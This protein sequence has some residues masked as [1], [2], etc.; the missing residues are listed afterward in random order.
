V[1]EGLEIAEIAA[2][3]AKLARGDKPLQT[4][5]DKKEIES[6]DLVKLYIDVGHKN[7]VRPQDIVGAIANEADIPGHAIGHIDIYD[8]FTFVE[9]P[10]RFKDQVLERMKLTKIRNRPVK[11]RAARFD[12]EFE[13]VAAQA[14]SSFAGAPRESR[15]SRDFRETKRPRESRDFREHREV[16]ETREA[17]P[18]NKRKEVVETQDFGELR[19]FT[20]ATAVT[21][22][23]KIKSTEES[24]PAPVEKKR[25]K[26]ELA[27]RKVG[28][29]RRDQNTK[30]AKP[31]GKGNAPA[32]FKNSKGKNSSTTN[33][34]RPKS[35]KR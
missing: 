15:E 31:K 19:D 24:L 20:R 16:K 29:K 13:E 33:S 5:V 27:L 30:S 1:E 22:P 28:P 12:N 7:N 10:R 4:V 14:E 25:S 3:A 11:I 34:G 9:L 8:R 32:P 6:D 21:K 26:A 2:A 23:E 18:A 17:R 35:K